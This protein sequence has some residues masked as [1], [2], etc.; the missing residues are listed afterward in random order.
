MLYFF[1]RSE[2]P[3][4]TTSLCIHLVNES[5]SSIFKDTINMVLL[6]RAE[7]DRLGNRSGVW[8]RTLRSATP[9]LM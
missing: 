5:I 4:F 7:V 9:P 1:K 6:A 2:I 3:S 8:L